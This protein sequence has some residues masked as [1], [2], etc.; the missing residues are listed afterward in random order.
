MTAP[1]PELSLRDA[2]AAQALLTSLT[3]LSARAAH[4]LLG[5]IHQAGALLALLIKRYKGQ[6]DPEADKLLEFLHSASDRVEVVTAGIRKYLEIAS[7]PPSFGPVD[8]N[9]SL[10][11]AL[12]LLAKPIQESG[13]V[14][15]ADSLGVLTADAAHMVTI[16][17]T[18]IGNSIKFRTPDT[19]PRIRVSL[20]KA[21]EITIADNGIGIDPEYSEAV[22][23]PFRR[24]NGREFA[25]A[26]LGLATAKLI[27]E[28]HGGNI[29]IGPVSNC[30]RLSHGTQ[31]RFTVRNIQS[32]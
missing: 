20:G 29:G 13:A 2:I 23:L 24:L 11:S 21:G 10:A 31:V 16:F 32:K 4:D 8:L 28:L 30:E 15:Q 26:G 12:E 7:R 27:C 17:D 3:E 19:P 22:F 6:L 18:L 1:Q 25:G 5:P 14:I 9:A